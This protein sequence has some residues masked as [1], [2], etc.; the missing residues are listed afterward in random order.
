MRVAGKTTDCR[1]D[2]PQQRTVAAVPS[3]FAAGAAPFVSLL[4]SDGSIVLMRCGCV[5][6]RLD[7]GETRQHLAMLE[8]GYEPG[9]PLRIERAGQEVCALSGDEARVHVEWLGRVLEG[10]AA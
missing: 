8:D 3:I 2:W 1:A 7:A 9:E 6:A 4:G 5:V 10:R